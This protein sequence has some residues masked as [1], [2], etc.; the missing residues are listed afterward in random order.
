MGTV[1][2]ASAGALVIHNNVQVWD[3]VNYG[4]STTT[5]AYGSSSSNLY[6]AGWDNRISS[7]M[8]SN[9][10]DHGF[11]FYT[12]A[13]Y[14]DASWKVCGSTSRNVMPTGFDNSIWPWPL[15][16]WEMSGPS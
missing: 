10:T 5:W 14:T 11:I 3:L 13:N 6:P 8:A 12:G 4:G 9:T 15:E 1:G 7:L 2:G 16:W